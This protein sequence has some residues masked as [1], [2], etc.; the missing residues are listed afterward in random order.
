[1]TPPN[2]S[3]KPCPCPLPEALRHAP[4]CDIIVDLKPHPPEALRHILPDVTSPKGSLKSCPC[5]LW[6]HY[7]ILPDVTSPNGSLKSLPFPLPEALRH[8]NNTPGCDV[9]IDLK[10]SL[11]ASLPTPGL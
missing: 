10:P 5:P 2:G 6:K 9:T 4:G 1:M 3:P 11:M 8:S 7:V